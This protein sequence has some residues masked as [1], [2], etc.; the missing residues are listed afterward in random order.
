MFFTFLHFFFF[1]LFFVS[2][3]ISITTTIISLS[4]HSG[5]TD[6]DLIGGDN[7]DVSPTAPPSFNDVIG[8]TYILNEVELSWKQ[9]VQQVINDR[10]NTYAANTFPLFCRLMQVLGVIFLMIIFL[11]N[12][13]LYYNYFC[14][15]FF[16]FSFFS[17]LL[18]L[19]WCGFLLLLLSEFSIMGLNNSFNS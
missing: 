13:I 8:M 15:F 18:L 7:S 2:S 11:N 4:I 3:F 6:F 10:C 16:F 1:S 14:F 9:H 5:A 12:F 19:F 17:L